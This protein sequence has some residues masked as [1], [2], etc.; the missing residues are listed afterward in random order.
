M[1]KTTTKT[2]CVA[3]LSLAASTAFSQNYQGQD[4]DNQGQNHRG[5]R[6]VSAPEIDPA[7]ALAALTLL[8]GTVAII[9]GYRHRRKDQSAKANDARK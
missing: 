4:D 6:P 1:V 5:G 7:Q 8:G 3:L 9:R 2:L